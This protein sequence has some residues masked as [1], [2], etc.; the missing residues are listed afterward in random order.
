MGYEYTPRCTDVL[1][2]YSASTLGKLIRFTTQRQ[3]EPCSLSNHVGG[4]V[5]ASTFVHADPPIVC[6]VQWPA[7]R[8]GLN[9]GDEWL[10]LGRVIPPTPDEE[11]FW[12]VALVAQ[13]GVKY[14]N[15]ENAAQAV[16]GF[17]GKL[18]GRDIVFARK[19]VDLLPWTNCSHVVSLAC[20]ACGWM[21]VT[22]R[23]N[24]PDSLYDYQMA[25]PDWCVRACSDG[26]G[27]VTAKQ[28]GE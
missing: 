12:R 21:P 24:A 25:S 15:V 28:E 9:P 6:P 20:I 17:I 8:A 3:G 7:Y 26:W 1:H 10:I 13:I 4:F 27:K 18:S 23:Y 14:S 16:D 2:K 11:M 19:S 5:S 22:G